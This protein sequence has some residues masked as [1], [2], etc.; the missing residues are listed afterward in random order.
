MGPVYMVVY[1]MKMTQPLCPTLLKP[2]PPAAVVFL[3]SSQ[4]ALGAFIPSRALLGIYQVGR[5]SWLAGFLLI[6][7]VQIAQTCR[8]E[9]LVQYVLLLAALGEHSPFRLVVTHPAGGVL[10]LSRFCALSKKEL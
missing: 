3:L 1:L 9:D 8:E 5:T 7:T 2:T 6:S 4:L 10:L